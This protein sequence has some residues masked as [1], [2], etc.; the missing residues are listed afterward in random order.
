MPLLVHADVA[1]KTDEWP[2]G[3][4]PSHRP[5]PWSLSRTYAATSDEAP[6]PSHEPCRTGQ[7]DAENGTAW[8]D[9]ARAVGPGQHVVPAARLSGSP[10]RETSSP[11]S[12]SHRGWPAIAVV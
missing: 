6:P 11:H 9:R 1:P 12:A 4:T 7:A 5:P 8:D 2:L 10:F 3:S